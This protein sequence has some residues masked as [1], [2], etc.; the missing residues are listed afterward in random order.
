M[1]A[2][3]SPPTVRR[4]Q[5][6]RELRKL[7]ES[8]GLHL[9]QLASELRCSPSR[10]SRIETARIRISPG[11]VHEILDV[12]GIRDDRRARLVGLARQAEEPGWWQEYTDS[13]TYEYAT[14]IALEAEASGIRNFEPLVI[15]GLLQTEE[16][17]RAVMRKGIPGQELDVGA[18]VSARIARQAVLR[19]DAPLRLFVLLGEAALRRPVGGAEVMHA[20]LTQLRR[21]AGK[22]RIR[23]QVVPFAAGELVSMHGSFSILEFDDPEEPAVAYVENVVGETYLETAAGVAQCSAVFNG[24]AADSLPVDESVRLIKRIESEL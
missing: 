6:G 1:V 17:A 8:V 7:R 15:P 16:Y 18:R 9:D 4:R 21:L 24:L 22:E 2:V 19:D 20:Q 5:L 12:L 13:L 3:G 23:V 11:T 10:V 14:Y